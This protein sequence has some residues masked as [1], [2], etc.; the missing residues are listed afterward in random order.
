MDAYRAFAEPGAMEQWIAPVGMS[1]RMLHF[2]FREG[3]SYRLRLT[4]IDPRSGQGKTAVDADDTHVRLVAITEGSRIEQDVVFDSDDPAF[5]GVMR[6][7]WTF[8]AEGQGTRVTVRAENVPEG[9]RPEDH[10]VG[11]D[12]TLEHLDAF[13]S[14]VT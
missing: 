11:L 6:M 7:I 3:G 13:V 1:A 4:Y 2:D 9:I 14:T 12:S 5:A 8:E 10:Q